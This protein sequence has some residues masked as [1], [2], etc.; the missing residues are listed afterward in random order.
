MELWKEIRIDADCAIRD[1]AFTVDKVVINTLERALPRMIR[2]LLNEHASLLKHAR[3]IMREVE[4]RYA[5]GSVALA[6]PA[7]LANTLTS[8]EIDSLKEEVGAAVHGEA[9][10][11]KRAHPAPQAVQPETGNPS[12]PDDAPANNSAIMGE[13]LVEPE[14]REAKTDALHPPVTNPV[15][16]TG[17]DQ[18]GSNS[19]PSHEPAVDRTGVQSAPVL[20]IAAPIDPL[21]SLLPRSGGDGHAPS[22]WHAPQGIGSTPNQPEGAPLPGGLPEAVD[23]GPVPLE[24]TGSPIP[25]PIKQRILVAR[26]TR[27]TLTT[28][29]GGKNRTVLI[30]DGVNGAVVSVGDNLTQKF[31]GLQARSGGLSILRAYEI[32]PMK[33]CD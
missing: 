23:H 18:G 20:P 10:T 33:P 11:A 15:P 14:G 16:T 9:Y 3:R 1:S 28:L 24:L 27:A 30:L 17:Q 12:S 31:I 29:R 25:K 26:L 21:E 2:R 4:T 8:A 6:L 32:E 7:S 13:E 22:S 5:N 19:P